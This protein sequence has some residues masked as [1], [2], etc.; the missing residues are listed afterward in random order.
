M[1]KWLKKFYSTFI[2]LFAPVPYLLSLYGSSSDI[3]L[4]KCCV[5]QKRETNFWETYPFK[6]H[7][8]F[9]GECNGKDIERFAF[10]LAAP[11]GLN[12]S[13]TSSEN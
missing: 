10:Y 8:R 5:P 12:A 9:L 13:S 3:L 7:L 11:A 1:L 6:K 4:K 2:V